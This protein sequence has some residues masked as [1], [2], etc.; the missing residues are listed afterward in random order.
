M[1]DLVAAALTRPL[2]VQSVLVSA[3]IDPAFGEQL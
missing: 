2:R 3:V 1:G